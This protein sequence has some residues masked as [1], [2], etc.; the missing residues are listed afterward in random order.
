[1]DFFLHFLTHLAGGLRIALA[2][3][4]A[5]SLLTRAR[6]RFADDPAFW[7]G[8]IETAHRLNARGWALIAVAALCFSPFQT[9][10][11][12]GRP[13]PLLW[14][15]IGDVAASGL[16]C[17]A[18]VCLLAAR[19]AMIGLSADRVRRGILTNVLVALL[20]VGMTWLTR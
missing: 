12:L 20:L 15:R 18:F 14:S 11:L 9:A 10:L 4:A 1:M 7:L 3:F 17:A 19:G 6:P 16:G 13:A 2:L 5:M 8:Q